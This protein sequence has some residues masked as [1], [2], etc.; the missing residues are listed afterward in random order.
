MPL[1]NKYRSG[2]V[3]WLPPHAYAIVINSET[4]SGFIAED[5]M[6][7]IF[8]SPARGRKKSNRAICGGSVVVVLMV[9]GSFYLLRKVVFEFFPLKPLDVWKV[10][11]GVESILV[12]LLVIKVTHPVE[13]LATLNAVPLGLSSNPGEGMDLCKCIVPSR[14]VSTLNS[15]RA[16]SPLVRLVERKERWVAHNQ[17]QGVLPQSWGETELNR[18][19]TCMVLKATAN[20]RRYLALCHDEFRG[21]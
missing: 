16:A 1:N 3:A 4:E 8:H 19:V 20:D 13:W 6:L 14:H 5:Y 15:R 2:P 12:T 11:N 17:K 18:S 21:P 9:V 7:P 10:V